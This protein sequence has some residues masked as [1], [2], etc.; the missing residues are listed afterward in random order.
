MKRVVI[1][2]GAFLLC[3]SLFA[4]WE[5]FDFSQT[6]ETPESAIGVIRLAFD[7]NGR[8]YLARSEFV[9]Y[10]DDPFSAEPTYSVLLED[11]YLDNGVQG[12]AVDADDNLFVVGDG[13]TTANP[14]S[15]LYKFDSQGNLLWGDDVI[16]EP[17]IQSS[18]LLSTGELLISNTDGY[19]NLFD[20]DDGSEIERMVDVGLGGVTR[21]IAVTPDDTVFANV[22]G[23]LYKVSGGNAGNMAGYS[24]ESFG[25]ASYLSTTWSVRPNVAYCGINDVVVSS[26]FDGAPSGTDSALFIQDADTGA[27][28]QTINDF[29]DGYS[30]GGLAFIE[31][32]GTIYLF[33][34][35]NSSYGRIYTQE[36]VEEVPEKEAVPPFDLE[37]AVLAGEYAWITDDDVYDTHSAAMNPATGNVLVASWVDDTGLKVLANADGSLLGELNTDGND[38][39]NVTALPSG[40]IIA[41]VNDDTAIMVWNEEVIDGP[42]PEVVDHTGAISSGRTL[43]AVESDGGEIIVL[44]GDARDGDFLK[45]TYDGSTWS[46]TEAVTNGYGNASSIAVEEDGSIIAKWVWEYADGTE[47]GEDGASFAYLDASGAVVDEVTGFFSYA[48]GQASL[49]NLLMSNVA[50][51]GQGNRYVAV[52]NYTPDFED[53]A[54]V[55]F[56]LNVH[57]YVGIW[58]LDTGEE[59]AS[60]I[61]PEAYIHNSIQADGDVALNI[62]DLGDGPTFYITTAIQ[63][64]HIGLF[65]SAPEELEVSD[66][67]LF[68]F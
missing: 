42:A 43:A 57:D 16:I 15:K 29:S 5:D 66:W 46:A 1:L 19:F 53:I 24:A 44:T 62:A 63:N 13:G 65:S 7:S 11:D 54:W 55:D 20:A 26:T 4:E 31:V 58:N 14:G 9:Y 50:V 67:S 27:L 25:D 59:V 61:I 38:P 30:A 18:V 49:D 8:L 35:G 33:V 12:L 17:R 28:L 39:R 48:D 23:S 34:T 2:I 22:S 36:V 37:W 60:I 56:P 64:N 47:A 52:A 41:S 3:F 21:G 40:T 45:Y 10:T 6:F 32:D 51:D 68:E